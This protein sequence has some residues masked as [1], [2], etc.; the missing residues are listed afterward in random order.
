MNNRERL[1]A[2]F[3]LNETNRLPVMGGWLAWPA[4]VA[5]RR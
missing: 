5:A 1:Q 3:D 4:H 2:A